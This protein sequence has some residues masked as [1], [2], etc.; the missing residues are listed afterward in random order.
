M[1]F[2][3]TANYKI[4]S[5]KPITVPA[6]TYDVI[7]IKITSDDLKLTLS[8]S[9][10]SVV[11]QANYDGQ[12]ELEKDTCRMIKLNMDVALTATIEGETGT[13]NSSM[14]MQLEHHTK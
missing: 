13:I 7:S 12:I 11:F 5:T 14:Q 2:V 8:S 1:S 9:D 3:G 6:G 10:E 4:V